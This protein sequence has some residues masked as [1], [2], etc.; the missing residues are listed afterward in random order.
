MFDS[1]YT[2]G[3]KRGSSG[4]TRYAKDSG[5]HLKNTLRAM[6][7]GVDDY[8]PGTASSYLLDLDGYAE[9]VKGKSFAYNEA[10]IDNWTP[11]AVIARWGL[12]GDWTV[13]NVNSINKENAIR[14]L[15]VFYD[16]ITDLGFTIFD[17]NFQPFGRSEFQAYANNIIS[18]LQNK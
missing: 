16:E 15:T 7:G 6:R 18:Q 17:E 11:K 4:F 5:E 14:S 13:N 9:K 12:A 1:G 2:I 8:I 10:F 3:G